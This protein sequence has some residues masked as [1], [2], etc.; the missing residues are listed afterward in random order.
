MSH[1]KVTG[2]HQP[3]MIDK[4]RSILN[5]LDEQNFPSINKMVGPKY[6][7]EDF[8]L[9]CKVE[10]KKSSAP[11][12]MLMGVNISYDETM[13]KD[14]IALKNNNKVV[15]YLV[16]V[17]GKWFQFSPTDLSLINGK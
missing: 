12:N 7:I 10:R 1:P 11:I 2:P 14:L 9:D 13:P 15:S 3:N 16:Q 5:E 17:N 4:W 8:L 6:V